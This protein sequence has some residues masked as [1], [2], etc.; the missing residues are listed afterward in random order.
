[1]TAV[2]PASLTGD[3]HRVAREI[4][5]SLHASAPEIGGTMAKHLHATIPELHA[6]DEQAIYEETEAS[7]TANM[8]QLL[9]LLARGEPASAMV[10]PE[11][12][13]R[14]AQGLVRRRIP[15]DVLLRAYRVGHAHLWNLTARRFR[16]EILREAELLPSLEASAAFM[17]EYVDLISADLV[18]AYHVERDRWVRS[19]AAVRAETARAIIEGGVENETSAGARLGYELRRP[20]IAAILSIDSGA[21]AD[22]DLSLEHEALSA[23]AA[24][25]CADVLVIPAGAAVLWAWFALPERPGADAPAALESHRPSAGVRMAVGRPAFGADGFRITHLEAQHAARF[26][27]AVGSTVSYRAIEVVSLLAADIDRARRFVHAELGPLATATESAA[28][29]RQTLLAFLTCGESH[30]RAAELLHMHHSSVYKRVRRAEEQLA[31]PIAARRVELTNAL[32][33]AQALGPE[34]LSTA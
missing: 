17:F 29:A 8:E 22:P 18:A 21:V 31:G 28:H 14:Y 34:V 19:A 12:A 5:G 11:P 13:L 3:R 15:L 4:V 1:M 24:L 30:T 26:W 33:L 25:N 32:M 7:C 27:S 16:A 10:V 23:A 6:P 2:Q 9:G 20:H